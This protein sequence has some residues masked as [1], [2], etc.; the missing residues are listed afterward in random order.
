MITFVDRQIQSLLPVSNRGLYYGDG[1]FETL[2]FASGALVLWPF[3]A[4]RLLRGLNRLGFSQAVDV[5]AIRVFLEAQVAAHLGTAVDA[6]VRL[7]LVRAAGVGYRPLCD[8]DAMEIISIQAYDMP[9]DRVYREGVAV[10]CLE[11]PL[12]ADRCLGGIKHLNRL[13]QVMAAR[14]LAAEEFEGL[15]LDQDGFLI[16]GTRSNLVA[17]R[18]GRWIT[19][20]LRNAGIEGVMR[21]FLLSGAVRNCPGLTVEPLVAGDILG[22]VTSLALINSVFGVVPVAMVNGRV[23]DVNPVIEVWQRPVHENLQLPWKART[24]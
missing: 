2:R 18:R 22:E 12:V 15:V 14:E 7:T 6:L 1:V 23:L 9:D 19:P 10:R 21:D 4:K 20:D 3:H 11:W 24:C 13:S 16:E 8:S 5:E 17:L